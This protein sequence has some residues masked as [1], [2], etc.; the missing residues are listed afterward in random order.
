MSDGEGTD[1]SDK[2]GTDASVKEGTD[3]SDVEDLVKIHVSR[4]D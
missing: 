2:E 3:G 4:G 1:G